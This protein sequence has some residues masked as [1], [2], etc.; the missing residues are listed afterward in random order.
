MTLPFLIIAQNP[1]TLRTTGTQ[2]KERVS[3]SEA[4]GLDAGSLQ[5]YYERNLSLIRRDD[6][7]DDLCHFITVA[8]QAT[9]G[10][11]CAPTPNDRNLS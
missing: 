7:C 5:D 4:S 1:P 10:L 8:I 2:V 6:P 9:L 3:I 11:H